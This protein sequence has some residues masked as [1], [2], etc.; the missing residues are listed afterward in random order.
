MTDSDF[1]TESDADAYEEIVRGDRKAQVIDG[2]LFC[3]PGGR[4]CPSFTGEEMDSSG[5]YSDLDKRHDEL[6]APEEAAEENEDRTPD[7][8]DTE[9]SQ[10]SQPSPVKPD[11]VHVVIDFLQASQRDLS[12][13]R[14]ISSIG[15]ACK[16]LVSLEDCNT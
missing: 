12:R 14:F 8:I 2:T 9:V 10:R 11:V 16:I 5:I 15:V 7:T 13:G 1:F 6:H 4:R 3:A